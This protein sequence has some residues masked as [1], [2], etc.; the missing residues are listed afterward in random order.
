MNKN[1]SQ[2]IRQKG[3]TLLEVLIAMTLMVVIAA[4]AFASLNGLI[5]AKNHTDIV[6]NNLRQELLTSQ[7]LN[8]DFHAMI[9]REVKDG[10]GSN[11]ASILGRYSS[12]EFSRNG[13]SNPLKQNRSELQRVQWF[14]KDQQLVRASMDQIDPGLSNRWRFRTYMDNVDELNVNYVNRAG[15]QSRS[16]PIANNNTTL[17]YI[18][19]SLTL[20]D[21]TRLEYLLRPLL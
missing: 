11:K 3:M 17:H 19:L 13:H 12:I 10:F 4:I 6:A 1:I 8:K 16:W 18:E 14:L 21:R 5:D 9:D 7:Q 15:L 20:S 2:H